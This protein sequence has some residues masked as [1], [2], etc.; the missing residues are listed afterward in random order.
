[1]VTINGWTQYCYGSYN[2]PYKVTGVLSPGIFT[3]TGGYSF[4]KAINYPFNDCVFMNTTLGYEA[5]WYDNVVGNRHIV[6]VVLEESRTMRGVKGVTLHLYDADTLEILDTQVTGIG[7]GAVSKNSQGET[8]IGGVL[9]D[10]MCYFTY[11]GTHTIF[12]A[13]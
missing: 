10:G 6:T 12:I 5:F 4:G 8:W 13:E 9:D 1:M 2:Q 3:S 7:T 11:S